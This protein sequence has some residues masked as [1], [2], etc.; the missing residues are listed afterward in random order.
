M[1]SV[2]SAR[3]ALSG[4]R[5]AAGFVAETLDV[6]REASLGNR[7]RIEQHDVL[8]ISLLSEDKAQNLVETVRSGSGACGSPT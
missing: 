1:P 2:D 4:P 8:F 5:W 3:A 7:P 6:S